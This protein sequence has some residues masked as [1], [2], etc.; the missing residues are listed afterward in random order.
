MIECKNKRGKEK[1]Y[2]YLELELFTLSY[3]GRVRLNEFQKSIKIIIFYIH[4]FYF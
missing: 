3:M 4:I 2:L 1:Y